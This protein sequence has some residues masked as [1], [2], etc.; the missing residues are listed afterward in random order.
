MKFLKLNGARLTVN[1]LTVNSALF[2]LQ[3]TVSVLFGKAHEVCGR[4]SNA[5]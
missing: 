1:M 3:F 4:F 2:G 5:M